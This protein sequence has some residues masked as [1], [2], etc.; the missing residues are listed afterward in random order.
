MAMIAANEAVRKEEIDFL[1]IIILL[2]S[3][4]DNHMITKEGTPRSFE[5]ADW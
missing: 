5:C 1:K 4:A 2:Q 3:T